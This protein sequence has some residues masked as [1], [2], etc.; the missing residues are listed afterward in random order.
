MI[1]AYTNLCWVS[2]YAQ[3]FVVDVAQHRFI[4][5]ISP[6]EADFARGYYVAPGGLAIFTLDSLSQV[7][8]IVIH[9]VAPGAEEKELISGDSWTKTAEA[10]VFFPSGRFTI[11]GPT[12][13]PGDYGPWFGT[14]SNRLAV[15][16]SWLEYDGEQYNL[17]RS[18][19][20][21]IKMDFWPPAIE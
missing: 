16:V 20:D 4:E 13:P 12:S 6:G 11:G 10:E 17:L 15:R 3:F 21:V 8:R 18:K 9:D 5:E 7:I 2:D 14:P 1:L 19:P